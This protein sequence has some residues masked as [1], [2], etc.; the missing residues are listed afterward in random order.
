MRTVQYSIEVGQPRD[1]V[2]QFAVD[3]G[4]M[5]S[6]VVNDDVRLS[7]A[8]EPLEVG[9]TY[10]VH[11]GDGENN[12]RTFIYEVVALEPDTSM[13]IRS[14]GRLLTYTTR[15]SFA[16]ESGKT[17]VSETIEMEDPPGMAKL[18]GGFMMGRVKKNHQQSL[19]RLKAILEQSE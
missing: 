12:R 11:N 14:A 6:W 15:R 3:P 17:T 8:D 9:S 10:T 18:L 13:A 2:Y 16:E 4:R 5:A 19:Q 1:V 7:I